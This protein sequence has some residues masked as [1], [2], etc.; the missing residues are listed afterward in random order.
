MG[1]DVMAQDDK[2]KGR[3]GR[4]E[5]HPGQPKAGVMTF[6]VRA[7]M[8]ENIQASAEK[9]GL[10]ISEEVERRLNLSFDIATNPHN[11]YVV[12]SVAEAISRVEEITRKS[13]SED[14]S[15]ARMCHSAVAAATSIMTAIHD[16]P[17]EEDEHALIEAAGDVIGLQTALH[18]A[19]YPTEVVVN[20]GRKDV[21][22][23]IDSIRRTLLQRTYQQ[24]KSHTE[25][26]PDG[27]IVEIDEDEGIGLGERP[28]LPEP[29]PVKREAVLQVMD[30]KRNARRQR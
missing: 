30:R 4:K 28:T 16:K 2:Q 29:D 19:G 12:R 3:P 9:R 13:W 22:L 11:D 8:R 7:G 6:R 21:D 10:S 24:V 14:L 25:R 20:Y 23:A 15:T 18:F 17:E 5:K 26:D 27:V 1:A